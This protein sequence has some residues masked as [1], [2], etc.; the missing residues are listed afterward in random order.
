MGSFVSQLARE[1]PVE[2]DCNIWKYFWID[3]RQIKF[4]CASEHTHKSENKRKKEY[5]ISREKFDSSLQFVHSLWT[6]GWITFVFA[7]GKIIKLYTSIYMVIFSWSCLSTCNISVLFLYRFSFFRFFMP[8]LQQFFPVA[9]SVFFSICYRFYL[10]IW[11]RCSASN[12][13]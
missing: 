6:S 5:E 12:G 3:W 4:S 9:G 13:L 2:Q 11:E 10:H 7:L 1:Q 8:F